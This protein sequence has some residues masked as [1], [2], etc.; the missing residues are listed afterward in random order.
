MSEYKQLR[1]DIIDAGI[2]HNINIHPVHQMEKLG[3]EII[4]AI[5]QSLG[6][7]WWLTVKEIIYPL[8]SYLEVMSYN[9]DYWHNKCHKNC[10][11][12]EKDTKCCWG[13]SKCVKEIE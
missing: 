9:F 10:E 8:P 6:D 3:Y 1:Y 5:P 2:N 4:G 13:G 7:Q 12:F 11:Y